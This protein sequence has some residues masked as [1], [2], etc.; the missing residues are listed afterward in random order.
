ME[1]FCTGVYSPPPTFSALPAPLSQLPRRWE[2][3]EGGRRPRCAVCSTASPPPMAHCTKCKRPL[4]HWVVVT[5]SDPFSCQLEHEKVCDPDKFCASCKTGPK[6]M[7]EENFRRCPRC[8]KV[9]YCSAECQSRHLR[10]H[11]GRC[12]PM[13]C[14]GGGGGGTG[15]VPLPLL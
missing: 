3:E 2:L 12:K 14:G 1:L 7:N 5:G 13:S 10:Y 8:A 6:P 11:V 15:V 9:Y 4:C